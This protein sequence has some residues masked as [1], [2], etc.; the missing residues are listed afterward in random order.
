MAY[1]PEAKSSERVSMTAQDEIVRRTRINAGRYQAIALAKDFLPFN[2]PILIWQIVS[3]KFLRPL[4]PFFMIGAL[5]FNLLALLPP[6][7]NGFWLLGPPWGTIFL[8]LQIIFYALAS[9][10][11][12]LQ[13]GEGQSRLTRAL[14]LPA[15]LV[16]S[17][18]AALKGF[19]RFL[20]GGQGHLWE[21]IQRR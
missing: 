20:R 3:H 11:A 14:Y 13:K 19:L 10:G 21:R 12:R 5:L 9:V 17:N 18:L 7:D 1:A 6:N 4:V 8:A 16:N 2:R 15:F